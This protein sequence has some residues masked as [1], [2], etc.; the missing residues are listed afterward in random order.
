MP[1]FLRLTARTSPKHGWRAISHYYVALAMSR[2][3]PPHVV[4][5]AAHISSRNFTLFFRWVSMRALRDILDA[6]RN[7][8]HEN[9]PPR[10]FR[11][12]S[13]G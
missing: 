6:P 8:G 9:I 4:K 10:R 2:Y 11:R 5:V 7:F 3:S 13:A 12:R 1:S